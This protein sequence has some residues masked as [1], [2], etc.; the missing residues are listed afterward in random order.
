MSDEG[1]MGSDL[2]DHIGDEDGD[3][4]ERDG[5]TLEDDPV[6]AD[7]RDAVEPPAQGAAA[8]ASES[9]ANPPD[10]STLNPRIRRR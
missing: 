3:L 6:A 1:P 7:T 10:T 5:I 2:E 8:P 4:A 9:A